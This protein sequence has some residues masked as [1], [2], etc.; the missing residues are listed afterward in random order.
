MSLMQQVGTSQ[1]ARA[2]C[3]IS[4]CTHLTTRSLP[5]KPP[6]ATAHTSP[7]HTPHHSPTLRS[8]A[9][10]QVEKAKQHRLL[11]RGQRQPRA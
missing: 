4:R 6:A 11:L 7:L 3:S 5:D 1:V 10:R 8:T 2:A 9:R